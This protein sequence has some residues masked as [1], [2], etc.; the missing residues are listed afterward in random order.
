MRNYVELGAT[1][2]GEDCVQVGTP[3]YHDL[4]KKEC[5]R[6]IDLLRKKF[7]EEPEGARLAIKSFPHD[8][9][10]YLEVVCYY[11]EDNEK[12]GEYAYNMEATSPE[13]WSE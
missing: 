2:F 6:Y 7:G 4:A 5:Q 1:P 3:D 13:Y 9:G 10:S 11:D 12:S 8:F